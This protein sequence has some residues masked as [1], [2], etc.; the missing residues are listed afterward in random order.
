MQSD[1]D[2]SRDITRLLV[3]YGSPITPRAVS[4]W[5]TELIDELLPETNPSKETVSAAARCGAVHV[6]IVLDLN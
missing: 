2:E 3:V 1:G 6:C 4:L 5:R